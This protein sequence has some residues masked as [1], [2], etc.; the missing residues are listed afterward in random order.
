MQG[1]TEEKICR[2]SA[3][4]F[5]QTTDALWYGVHMF[6]FAFLRRHI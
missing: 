4:K 5:L 2:E 1:A 3:K 6:D